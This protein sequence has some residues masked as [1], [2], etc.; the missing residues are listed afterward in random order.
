MDGEHIHT[1]G[2][3][4]T[5]WQRLEAEYATAT[6]ERQAEIDGLLDAMEFEAWPERPRC[7]EG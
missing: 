7:E 4:P 6:P 1:N 5:E 2:A 3:S